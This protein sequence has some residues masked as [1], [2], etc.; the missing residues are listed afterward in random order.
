MGTKQKK[1]SPLDI[2]FEGGRKRITP[3]I[4]KLPDSLQEFLA[5]ARE[6]FS[7]GELA[8]VDGPTSFRRFAAQACDEHWP[9]VK[10]PTLPTI[11]RWLYEEAA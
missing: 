11:R 10:M 9:S 8:G 3:W 6:L 4:E 2:K 5:E 7:K 1:I